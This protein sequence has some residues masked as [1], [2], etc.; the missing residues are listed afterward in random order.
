MRIIIRGA[1]VAAATTL[2]IGMG[3]AAFAAPAGLQP[4]PSDQNSANSDNCIAYYSA[5]WT[6]N[7]QGDTL[8]QGDSSH[9]QRGDEIKGLQATCGAGA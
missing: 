9:G 5:Q 1:V 3:G 7:G 8:G 2:A 6:H 4:N